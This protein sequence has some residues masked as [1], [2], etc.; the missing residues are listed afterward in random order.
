MVDDFTPLEQE[1][2]GD[3]IGMYGRLMRQIDINLQENHN[4]S[5]AEFEVLLRLSWEPN[6]RL[7]IQDLAA[8]SML[9]RSGIS[10]VVERL[11][12]ARLVTREGAYEDRRGTYAVLTE[13][14]LARFQAALTSHVAFVQRHFLS[15]FS[16]DELMQMAKFWQRVLKQENEV[17]ST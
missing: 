17:V 6:H 9:T 3:L 10:R 14:G 8:R 2:W 11:A 7:R 4:I 5:H 15:L 1:A 16:E 12:Q 13:A